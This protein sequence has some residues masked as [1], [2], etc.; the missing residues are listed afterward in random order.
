[1]TISPADFA[2]IREAARHRDGTFGEHL[3]TAPEVGLNTRCRARD[4]DV[5]LADAQRFTIDGILHSAKKGSDRFMTVQFSTDPEKTEQMRRL[6]ERK[7]MQGIAIVDNQEGRRG[8]KYDPERV[9]E[10]HVFFAGEEE[11]CY[12]SP[13]RLVELM[14]EWFFS[15]RDIPIVEADTEDDTPTTQANYQRMLPFSNRYRDD[16][17]NPGGMRDFASWWKEPQE[18]RGLGFMDGDAVVATEAGFD[19]LELKGGYGPLDDRMKSGQSRTLE[20]WGKLAGCRAYAVDEG[21]TSEATDVIE[22]SGGPGISYRTS[23]TDLRDA[24]V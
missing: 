18:M 5:W 24:L 17:T 8:A 6:S 22:Y 23:L 3:H 16:T 12:V 21:G 13:A 15:G 10:V 20:A 9:L 4:V 1:M 14:H 19:L 2:R 7:G 11:K